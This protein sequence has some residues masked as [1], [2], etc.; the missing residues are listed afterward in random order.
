MPVVRRVS[1]SLFRET[2]FNFSAESLA[3]EQSALLF[4]P[5]VP[6]RSIVRVGICSRSIA[7]ARSTISTSHLLVG[8]SGHMK[9]HSN[10]QVHNVALEL[11]DK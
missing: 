11:L 7:E 5:E 10:E 4:P 8:S 2:N 1:L 9:R 6:Q 3:D